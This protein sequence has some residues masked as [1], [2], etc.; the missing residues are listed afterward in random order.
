MPINHRRFQESIT[1]ELDVIRNRVRD[2]IG[3]AHWG[4]EGR[5]KEEI[6][7]K[8]LRKFLPNNVSVGSGFVATVDGISKQLDII[9]YD[10]HQ[11]L[12]FSEGDF[13]ITTPSNVLGIIE[14][15][16]RLTPTS[17]REAINKY[18]QSSEILSQNNQN[19]R[20]IFHGL[21]SFEYQGNIESQE[22]DTALSNSQGIVNHIS[23]GNR[24]FIRRWNQIEGSQLRPEVVTSSDFYNVYDIE[25][26]SFSYFISNLIDIVS[27]GLNDRYWIAFPIENTKEAHR[28]RTVHMDGN[29]A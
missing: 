10:N 17:L 1:R 2:L 6:L 27:G 5:Y 4:E 15:K 28:L 11:P 16:S 25:D 13:I 26:L 19:E 9:I 8:T 21:F 7:K 14:V 3:D 18:D 22:I 20:R 12:L 24:Y 29:Q 23:L